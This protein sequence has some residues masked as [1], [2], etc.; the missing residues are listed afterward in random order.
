MN[1]EC[2][3]VN[4]G[5]MRT[6]G[7]P[8]ATIPKLHYSPFSIQYSQFTSLPSL[9]FI[10]HPPGLEPGTSSFRAKRANQLRHR[11]NLVGSERF[12]LPVLAEPLHI[13]G[14]MYHHAPAHNLFAL[15]WV[16]RDSNSHVLSEPGLQPGAFTILPSTRLER[17]V[18][19]ELRIVKSRG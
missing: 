15:Q 12:E 1:S 16:E 7:R 5:P 2:R 11:C 17:I 14:R 19:V 10:T 9:H 13:E 3:I 4:C 6:I 8:H 18:N